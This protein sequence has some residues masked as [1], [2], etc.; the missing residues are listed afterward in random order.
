MF[1]DPKKNVEQFGIDPGSKVADF[2]SGVGFYALELA[3][4]VGENGTVYAVDIQEELLTKLKNEISNRNLDN[5]EVIW[6]DIDELYGSKLQ[7]NLVDKVLVA[8]VLFLSD[9]KERLAEEA[10]RVL[11]PKG[12]LLLVDWTDSFGGL[13]PHPSR[14]VPEDQGRAIF[15]K[16]GFTFVRKIQAGDH[17]YGIVFKK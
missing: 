11:K 3:E 17:H 12:M 2:G 16:A 6:G 8:N 15:E 5:I 7:N 4:A 9:D 14:V 13:G 10:K 1:S